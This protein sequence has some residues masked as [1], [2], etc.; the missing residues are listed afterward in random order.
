MSD[1]SSFVFPI[2]KHNLKKNIFITTPLD[3]HAMT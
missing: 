1:E 2:H 3:K